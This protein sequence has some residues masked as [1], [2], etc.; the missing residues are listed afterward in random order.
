MSCWGIVELTL[1]RELSIIDGS[2]GVGISV[3]Q[4]FDKLRDDTSDFIMQLSFK[5]E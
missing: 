3:W 2:T 1:L 5:W 4:P